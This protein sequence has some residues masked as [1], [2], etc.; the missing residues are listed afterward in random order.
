MSEV[1][2]VVWQSLAWP[3]IDVFYLTTNQNI[4]G[5]GIVVGNSDHQVAFAIEYKVILSLAWIVEEVAIKSL[6]DDRRLVLKHTDGKWRDGSGNHLGAFDGVSFIDISL[7][8]FTNT[9][10][11]RQLTFDADTPQKI[12]VIYIDL[13]DF[14]LRSVGQYYSKLGSDTY[15]YQDVETPDFVADIAVDQDGLVVDYPRLFKRI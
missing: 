15:R 9:L 4:S 5:R 13:P 7:S 11:I 2:K 1:K 12:D 10:P 14:S 3:A 6:L 8:P